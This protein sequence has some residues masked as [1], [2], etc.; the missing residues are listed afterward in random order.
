[1]YEITFVRHALND[2]SKNKQ[3]KTNPSKYFKLFRIKKETE[4][5]TT[6][7]TYIHKQKNNSLGQLAAN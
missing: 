1:V 2:S 5:K 4:Q 7:I 3:P 6:K